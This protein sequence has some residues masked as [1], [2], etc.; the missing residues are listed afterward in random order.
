L[1]FSEDEVDIEAEL[2]IELPKSDDDAEESEV[3][4]EE[5]EEPAA[6]P[7]DE[8]E[9]A[10]AA[11]ALQQQLSKKARCLTGHMLGNAGPRPA[12]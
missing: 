5:D 2:G 3:E 10:A 12:A 7:T 4:E 8:S 9:A 11:K 6:A 1:Q